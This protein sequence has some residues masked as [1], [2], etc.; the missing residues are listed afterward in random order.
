MELSVSEFINSISGESGENTTNFGHFSMEYSISDDE[1]SAVLSH[2]DKDG[3][4]NS[5][6]SKL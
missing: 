3:Q 1:D 4:I 2:Q 6:R 5:L